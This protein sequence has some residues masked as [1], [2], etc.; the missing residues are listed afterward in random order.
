MS[1]EYTEYYKERST[2]FLNNK[3]DLV[4]CISEERLLKSFAAWYD[5]FCFP[6]FVL[7]AGRCRLSR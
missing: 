5:N 4:F 3:I 7:A 1:T 6:Q 2:F